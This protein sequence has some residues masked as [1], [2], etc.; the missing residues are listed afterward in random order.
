MKYT[1]GE[2]MNSLYREQR[3]NDLQVRIMVL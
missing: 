3:H 1:V 2:M